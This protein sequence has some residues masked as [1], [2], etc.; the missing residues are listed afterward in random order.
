ME[1]E[2]TFAVQLVVIPPPKRRFVRRRGKRL[3]IRSFGNDFRKNLS[4][5]I[6]RGGFRFFF[7]RFFVVL[8]QRGKVE[9][10]D[11]NQT[12]GF[13][14]RLRRT[15]LGFGRRLVNDF[16]NLRRRRVGFERLGSCNIIFDKALRFRHESNNAS[17]LCVSGASHYDESWNGFNVLDVAN[18]GGVRMLFKANSFCFHRVDIRSRQLANSSILKTRISQKRRCLRPVARAEPHF[19]GSLSCAVGLMRS[20]AL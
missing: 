7:F 20:N 9:I 14:L 16:D 5:L 19:Q 15:R 2:E 3:R 17:N 18:F 10:V 8:A 13:V 12:F 11:G 4:I 1:I 6:L